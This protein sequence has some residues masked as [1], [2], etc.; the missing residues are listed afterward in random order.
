MSCIKSETVIGEL[1]DDVASNLHT[2]C[3]HRFHLNTTIGVMIIVL[4]SS[5]VDRGFEPR[6]D[7]SKDY[8]IGISCFSTLY[9][10]LRRKSIDWLARNQN[11]VSEWGK[12]FIRGLLLKRASTIKTQ[13]SVLV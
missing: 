8:K 11:N 6:S 1:T 13:L 7:Q 3:S 12:M 2:I 9:A 5:T 4:T 10:A